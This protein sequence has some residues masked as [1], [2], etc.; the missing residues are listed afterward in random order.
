MNGI[1]PLDKWADD[2]IFFSILCMHLHIY[3]L[4]RQKWNAEIATNTRHTAS[5]IWYDGVTNRDNLTEE[6]SEDCCFPIRDLS[7]QAVRSDDSLFTYNIADVDEISHN[8][9]ISWEVSKDQPFVESTTYIGF[10]WNL[11]Q[12]MVTISPAKTEKYIGAINSWQV[13]HGHSLK[14]V[15][16]LH[17]KLPHAASILLQGHAYLTGLESMLAMCAKKPFTP[18]QSDKG[19]DQDLKWWLDR[20]KGGNIICP[21]HPLP[22][23]LDLQAFSNA[24]SG[25]G[26]G[27]TIESQW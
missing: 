7:N 17:G 20:L 18:H 24:S 4:A 8:L 5:G 21:I 27:I 9:G 10:V 25:F 15:Q 26:I 2:H 6:F 12:W 16:E 1:E 3:N 22:I 11:S 13:R 19:L 23:F 14:D